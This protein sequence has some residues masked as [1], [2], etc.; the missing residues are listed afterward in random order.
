MSTADNSNDPY[1]AYRHFAADFGMPTIRRVYPRLINVTS[2]TDRPENLWT[3]IGVSRLLSFHRLLTARLGPIRALEYRYPSPGDWGNILELVP[4]EG[5]R[6]GVSDIGPHQDGDRRPRA[7]LQ[8]IVR[9][10]LLPAYHG[11]ALADLHAANDAYEIVE[12][13]LPSTPPH[14][15]IRWA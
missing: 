2:V 4:S 6:G 11:G 15:N 1:L 14:A 9:C 7:Y 12:S 8:E 5:S 10:R 3:V 13:V